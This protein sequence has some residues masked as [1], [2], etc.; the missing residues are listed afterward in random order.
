[1]KTNRDGPRT[2]PALFLLVAFGTLA[3]GRQQLTALIVGPDPGPAIV[4][5]YRHDA[6]V[7]F[8]E[9]DRDGF[10]SA[11]RSCRPSHFQDE[12]TSIEGFQNKSDWF[13]RPTAN[14]CVIFEVFDGY[15][16][17]YVRCSV[18]IEECPADEAHGPSNHE[19]DFK[20]CI[21]TELWRAKRCSRLLTRL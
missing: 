4:E 5:R 11:I 8:T 13:V 21:Q 6:S 9:T 12:P 20:P 16:D 1:M 17:P 7:I 15:S 10:E 2:F 14:G 19:R 3:C 18:L